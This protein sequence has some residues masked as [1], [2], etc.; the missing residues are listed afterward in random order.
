MHTSDSHQKTTGQSSDTSRGEDDHSAAVDFP[1]L[2]QAMAEF[3]TA[4]KL[5][6]TKQPCGRAERI[7]WRVAQA[8]A[9][10]AQARC[11]DAYATEL[12]PTILGGQWK[13]TRKTLKAPSELA[14]R[15]EYPLFGHH[16][17]FDHHLVF[18][19]IGGVPGST[20]WRNCA[21]IGLPYEHKEQATKEAAAVVQKYGVGVWTRP[22]LSAWY[23]GWT[24]LVVAAI[25]L[26]PEDA[27]RCGFKA[28][29]VPGGGR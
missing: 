15:P 20:A 12:L 1:L 25:G 23:P 22:D 11:E 29:G 18:R 17:L 8:A 27:A 28:L 3:T 5:I 13:R 4:F 14:G 6:P 16:N 9:D 24:C 26:R 21:A 19:R 2:R 7:A 10:A